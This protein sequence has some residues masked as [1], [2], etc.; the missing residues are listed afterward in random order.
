MTHPGGALLQRD[1][2]HEV[3]V[4]A[5]VVGAVDPADAD[6]LE[7][8]DPQDGHAASVVVHDLENVGTC[9]GNTRQRQKE[10]ARAKKEGTHWL[11]SLQRRDLEIG[12]HVKV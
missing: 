8:G 12:Q 3:E 7:D 10:A 11:V 2:Q 6:H 1:V 9:V 5:H 4:L